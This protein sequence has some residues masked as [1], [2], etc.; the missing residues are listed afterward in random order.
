MRIYCLL[1]VI[2]SFPLEVSGQQ[3]RF[4]STDRHVLGSEGDLTASLTFFDADGDGD[5][6]VVFANGRHWAQVNE[7]Y[8]NNGLGQFTYGYPVGPE[9]ATSYAAPAGDLDGD[10]DMDLVIGNDRAENWV[11]LNDGTGRF[12]IAWIVSPEIEPT[13]SAQLYDINSDGNLDV[14]VTNRGATNGFY[15]NDG[16]GRFGEKHAFGDPTGSTIAVA[17]ADLNGDGRTD[18]VLANRDGQSNKILLNEGNLNFVEGSSFGTGTD[19]TRGVA[20][21]DLN[22][23][24][25]FFI[26]DNAST[27][28][29]RDF[30]LQQDDVHLFLAEGRFAESVHG[31]R[32]IN[33]LV[34]RYG[35]DQWCIYVD[36]DEALVY[37]CVEK[38]NLHH[39]ISYMQDN[40]HEALSGFMMD[41]HGQNEEKA[42]NSDN[43]KN[44]ITS[45]PF[46]NNNY[47]VYG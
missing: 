22:N 20:L 7:V 45:Y 1:F 5:L 38:F 25:Q 15:L 30:L 12:E 14:L 21:A 17:A 13:R 24:G 34:E 42:F 41:M 2:W 31:M 40:K 33:H 10:G 29:S 39:L 32:W 43:M 46:F 36:A 16:T 18:L 6:D 27:D 11:Y 35:K 9:K 4:I 3:P 28:G 23:D 8:L 47:K 19:E 37:P 26:V 44:L